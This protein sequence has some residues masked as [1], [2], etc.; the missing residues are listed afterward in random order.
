[1]PAICRSSPGSSSCSLVSTSVR[2]P[3]SCSAAV[4]V[5][6]P[7]TSPPGRRTFS[8]PVR[9]AGPKPTHPHRWGPTTIRSSSGSSTA[10]CVATTETD[11]RQNRTERPGG[12]T[13]HHRGVR[14]R[15][16]SVLQ[17][18]ALQPGVPGLG[19]ERPA[20]ARLQLAVGAGDIDDVPA[21]GDVVE[22]AGAGRRRTDATVADVVVA[23][24]VVLAGALVDVLTAVADPHR[25]GDVLGVV[26]GVALLAARRH[27]VHHGRLL[28]GEMDAAGG[29]VLPGGAHARADRELLHDAVVVDLLVVRLGVG[30]GDVRRADLEGL[31]DVRGAVDA[32]QPSY[33]GDVGGDG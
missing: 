26:A 2:S 33:A 29:G 1:M 19:P 10:A 13:R 30:D 7:P 4:A 17:R 14:G 9:G 15:Y 27:H 12:A 18:A 23:Q 3:G 31:G 28:L 32:A 16:G 24:G 25:Q 11:H 21:L 22:P 5:S 20:V 8:S 6:S